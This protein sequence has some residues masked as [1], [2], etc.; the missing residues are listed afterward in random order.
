MRRSSLVPGSATARRRRCTAP[1]SS[2]RASARR[3]ADPSLSGGSVR[4][5]E[6]VLVRDSELDEMAVRLL[7]VEA[8]DL[9]ERAHSI[10]G[11]RLDPVGEPL[12]ELGAEQPWARRR[13][14]R[15]G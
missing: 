9:L 14:P 7:E 11:V 3:P 12:V 6:R 13:R 1:R 10:A 8:D 4:E 5:C 2:P 15:C